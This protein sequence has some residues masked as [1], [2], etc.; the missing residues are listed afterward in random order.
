MSD[1]AISVENISKCYRIGTQGGPA[2]HRLS[3]MIT[4]VPQALWNA[5][6]SLVRKSSIAAVAV[7]DVQN[8]GE[9]WALKDVS[10]EIK[11]G[12]VVG[13][14][15]RNGAGKSTL[16][17][18]LSRITEPTSGR[19]GVRGRVA[20]LLEVGTGFHPELTGRENIYVSGV[21]LGMTRAEIKKR[22]DEIVDFS[23]VEKFLDTPAKHYSSGMQMR[24]AFPVAAHLDCEVLLID[25]VLAVG[26]AEFQ[27]KCVGR[28]RGLQDIGRTVLI[29]SHQSSTISSL[30]NRGIVLHQGTIEFIGNA[31]EAVS[32]HFPGRGGSANSLHDFD[33]QGRI[34]GN[35]R[36]RLHRAWTENQKGE[37]ARCFDLAEPIYIRMEYST[38]RSVA[39]FQFP[40][41]HVYDEQRNPVFV[42]SPAMCE[43][44]A[45]A[46]FEGRL[47]A[48]CAIPQNLLN[49]G[50]FFIGVAV[51][52]LDP[53]IDVA[54]HEQ[55]L[56]VIE[57]TEDVSKT[58]N[59]SRN[60]YA[61]ALPGSLRPR[62]E[63]QIQRSDRTGIR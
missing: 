17:K 20:S 48:G 54:F 6:K 18:I 28:M 58:I 21:T 15:G 47:L 36:A 8:T 5:G 33:V 29:V 45:T 26:D 11:Q 63:W 38:L 3:E 16:L 62:L 25:E 27:R 30:C 13:I 52:S 49:T 57:I 37:I 2:Y 1:V 24:L 31:Q 61:G 10:F 7:P 35:H 23:G 19:F 53:G 55:D 4:G 50:L 9:F 39:L 59:T 34:V 46:N 43:F 32:R 42:T 12:E 14:I 51:T 40:N 56:L 41:F 22:F 60:H 44:A